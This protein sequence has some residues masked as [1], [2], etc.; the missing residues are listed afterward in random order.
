MSPFIKKTSFVTLLTTL[1]SFASMAN[2]QSNSWRK[3][4][5]EKTTW[6]ATDEKNYSAFIRTLGE[7]GCN[8]VDKCLRSP[9][10][11]LATDA[12]R[13]SVRWTSDCG[14]FPYILRAYFAWK[15]KL[16]FSYT[17]GVEAI[18]GSGDL[19]YS[20]KGNRATKR[21]SILQKSASEP[22][23][24]VNAVK[25]AVRD[26]YT[27][28]Y[29]FPPETDVKNNLYFD[30]YSI[31]I[32][33]EQ[34]RPGSIVYDANGHVVVIYKVEDDGR[35][36]YFDAHPDNS[37]SRGVYGQKFARATPGMGA[38]FKNF[39]P[40][41]LVGATRASNN[42]LLGGQIATLKNADLP[43]YSTVQYYGNKL[44]TSWKLG[45]FVLNGTEMNY[46]DFVRTKLAIGELKYHP[47]S[48][49]SNSLD[50]LCQDLRDRVDAVNG[51][52]MDGIHLKPQPA[53]LPKNIYGADGEWE[54]FSTPSRDA[55]LKVSFQEIRTQ[56]EVFFKMYQEHNPRL[57]YYGSDLGADMRLAYSAA[58]Q[59]CNISYK[60]T[61]GDTQI[62]TY[63][64]A[65]DRLFKMS[66]DPYHC[67]E[68]RWGATDTAELNSCN[69]GA[70][71][72]AWY[73]A[74]QNLRNQLERAYDI[75]MGFTLEQLRK[76]V[77]GSGT[78][79]QVDVDLKDYLKRQ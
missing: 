63:D 75:K 7:S 59:K 22:I 57:E 51:A 52:I 33:R 11:Y 78:A 61:N 24:G 77:P 49:L 23:D 1:L 53:N 15:N 21:V 13:Q 50:A 79:V 43:G 5:I 2:A 10:N 55:R 46:Y 56:V 25:T 27:A 72:R 41:M 9:A 12:E 73:A 58:S 20:A 76:N 60:K 74:E 34:I 4:T 30:L 42:S 48:E 29:R 64:D 26:I 36:R 70:T 16:P 31:D 19:R 17:S 54:S 8:S 37:V 69:D 47:L 68:K 39:R 35:I 6:T 14:R 28:M 44:G 38:G 45:R 62:L 71:K 65:V 3:W 66:F 18:D 67:V 40:I 32:D